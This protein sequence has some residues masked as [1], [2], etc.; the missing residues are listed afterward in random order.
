MREVVG[1]VDA[2]GVARARVLGVEDP[3]Q[4][5]VAQVDVRGGHVD[6]RPQDPG[7]VRELA[8]AH[9]REEVEAL[10]RR[11]VAPRAVSPGLGEGATVLADLVG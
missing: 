4:D 3:V 8:G 10:F 2:P 11:A 9:A 1:R 7:S 6:L 5:G